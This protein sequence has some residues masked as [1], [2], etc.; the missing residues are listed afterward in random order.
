MPEK[1]DNCLTFTTLITTPNDEIL[2]G[3][4]LSQYLN[5]DQGLAAVKTVTTQ[6]GRQNLNTN[7]FIKVQI[8]F[9]SLDEQKRISEFLSNLDHLITLHQRE[10]AAS[11]D[12]VG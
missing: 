7:D 12:V 1:Y 6:G 5:S 10:R 11:D 9:P 4:F 3:Y 2:D 8:S